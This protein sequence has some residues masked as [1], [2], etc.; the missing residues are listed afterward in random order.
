LRANSFWAFTADV[1]RPLHELE[2]PLDYRDQ[3]DVLGHNVLA[4][5]DP[6]SLGRVPTCSRSSDRGIASSLV[7]PGGITA[8]DA[9]P[10]GQV[11]ASAGGVVLILTAFVP[12]IPMPMVTY[13]G[14][15][16]PAS[17]YTSPTLPSSPRGCHGP[18][19]RQ[20]AC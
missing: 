12:N 3:V 18:G 9:V 5:P 8:L 4:Q 17:R 16:G 6:V 11:C 20:R 19:P 15:L 1:D 7:G 10:V 13:G 2:V 14:W